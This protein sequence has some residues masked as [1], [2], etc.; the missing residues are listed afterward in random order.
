VALGWQRGPC[1]DKGE[2]WAPDEL[3]KVVSDLLEA[4]PKNASL[5]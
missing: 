4:S 2:R 1:I 3:G 5:F